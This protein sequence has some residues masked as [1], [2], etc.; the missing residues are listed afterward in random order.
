MSSTLFNVYIR[1]LEGEMRKEQTRGVVIEKEKVRSIIYANDI[2]LLVKSEEELQEMM[3]RF[4]KYVEK[5]GLILDLSPGKSKV[6]SGDDGGREGPPGL[7]QW[8]T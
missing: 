1:D 4:K 5:K 6:R 3:K 8:A 7:G 2:I